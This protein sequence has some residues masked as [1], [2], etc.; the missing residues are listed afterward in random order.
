MRQPSLK[1]SWNAPK[2]NTEGEP[3]AE[4]EI[5]NLEFRI[6]ENGELAVDEIGEID[7]EL[8]MEDKPEGQYEY[9]MTAV[10]YGLESPHS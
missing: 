3:L 5:N 7:F 9:T 8:L 4:E 1:F 6:Y 10:L 2:V